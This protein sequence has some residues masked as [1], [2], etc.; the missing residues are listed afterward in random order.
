MYDKFSDWPE[1]LQDTP[2]YNEYR[3]INV[4][5][6]HSLMSTC[7]AFLESGKKFYSLLRAIED[8]YLVVTPLAK[9]ECDKCCQLRPKIAIFRNNVTAHVNVKRRQTDW[10]DLAGIKNGEIDAFMQSARTAV[11]ELGKSN[12]H[13]EFVA[14]SRTT[15]QHNFRKFCRV[16]Q[17]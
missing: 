8:P 7:Y 16:M 2:E 17:G 3:T 13:P 6:S 1:E 12:V 9:S 14:S 11:E 5:L 4:L 10:A 15:F